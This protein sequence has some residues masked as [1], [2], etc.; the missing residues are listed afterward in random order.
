MLSIFL[1]GFSCQDGKP[2]GE[3]DKVVE[4]VSGTLHY[5]AE[6]KT[7]YIYYYFPGTIDSVDIYL[8]KKMQDKN[9]PFEEGKKVRVSGSCYQTTDVSFSV[10][11]GTTVYYII[12]TNLL[13][14]IE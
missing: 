12:V 1:A 13:E 5:S 11:A 3:P 9:F 2:T 7:W 8:I 4:N 10:F 14:E 6:D